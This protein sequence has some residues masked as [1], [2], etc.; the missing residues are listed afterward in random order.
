MHS[1]SSSLSGIM[2]SIIYCWAEGLRFESCYSFF[3]VYL[4]SVFDFGVNIWANIWASV[5]VSMKSLS[6][7][8]PAL[9]CENII[10]ATCQ[11]IGGIDISKNEKWLGDLKGLSVGFEDCK[12]ISES[13]NLRSLDANC[14]LSTVKYF[15]AH[16]QRS[17]FQI[18]DN[19]CEQKGEKW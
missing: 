12:S 16:W 13:Q 14:R 2:V 17:A 6:L 7:N 19:N 10:T 3:W 8:G 11:L 9:T 4:K 18:F 1:I 5:W 15:N